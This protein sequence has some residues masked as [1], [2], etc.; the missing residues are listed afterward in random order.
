LARF[1]LPEHG[2]IAGGAD[3]ELE[4]VHSHDGCGSLRKRDGR[5]P[6][7]ATEVL[8]GGFDAVFGDPHREQVADGVGPDLELARVLRRGEFM[9]R[10]PSPDSG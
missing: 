3:G 5:L 6:A 8:H 1:L 10:R 7:G 4:V 2:N 9:R